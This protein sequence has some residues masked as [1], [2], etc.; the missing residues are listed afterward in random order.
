LTA[1]GGDADKV[2]NSHQNVHQHLH[3]IN[4]GG[5]TINNAHNDKGKI[6]TKS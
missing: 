5:A 6:L 1:E 3:V 4:A 2:K